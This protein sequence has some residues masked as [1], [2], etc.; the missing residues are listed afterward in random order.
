M[1][2]TD[3]REMRTLNR[4]YRKKDKTTDVLSFPAEDGDERVKRSGPLGDLV[5]SV[6]QAKRQAKEYQHSLDQEL[7]RLIVHGFLHLLGYDHEA[8]AARRRRMEGLE[9]ELFAGFT[10]PIKKTRRS[11]QS[12]RSQKT[13]LVSP[14]KNVRKKIRRT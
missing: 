11:F 12:G 1:L 6:P 8:S 3:D 13:L 5:I 14:Q 10:A 7:I 2:L 4:E 9:S